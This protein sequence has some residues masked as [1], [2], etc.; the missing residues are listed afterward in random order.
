MAALIWSSVRQRISL[1]AQAEVSRWLPVLLV[2]TVGEAW[3]PA[4]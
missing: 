3:P 2:A 1:T 4:W